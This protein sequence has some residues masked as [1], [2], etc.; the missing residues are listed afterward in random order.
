MQVQEEEKYIFPK[1]VKDEEDIIGMI[2]YSFYKFEKMDFI[3]NTEQIS[4]KKLEKD[5][6]I[7]FQDLK[8]KEI[9]KYKKTAE[10]T[11]EKAIKM[12]NSN[13]N[14]EHF[15]ILER[16]RAENI[17][18]KDKIESKEK[19]LKEKENSLNSREKEIKAKE[20]ELKNREKYCHIK[21]S[22]QFFS[23]LNGVFQ[24]LVATIIWT[25]LVILI[26]KSTNYDIIKFFTE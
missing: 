12:T 24:G 11:L 26:I 7:R 16:L 23:F 25:G 15:K 10:E 1:I 5:E 19:G 14:F 17:S 4:G 21:P 3:K 9:E 2:A 13:R 22:N 18:L 20:K 6:L 8:Y